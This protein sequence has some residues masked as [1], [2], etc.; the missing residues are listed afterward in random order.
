MAMYVVG[1]PS[2]SRKKAEQNNAPPFLKNVFQTKSLHGLISGA[3]PRLRAVPGYVLIW[4]LDL[5]CFT[6]QAVGWV[7]FQ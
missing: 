2:S 5:A 1:T 4:V 6:V 7:Q 3:S